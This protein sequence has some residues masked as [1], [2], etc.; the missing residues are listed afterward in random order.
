MC[1][2]ITWGRCL[3]VTCVMCGFHCWGLTLSL[4]VIFSGQCLPCK[5]STRYV[6][7][8]RCLRKPARKQDIELMLQLDQFAKYKHGK[9]WPSNTTIWHAQMHA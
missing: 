7:V 4:D 3:M 2:R 5:I 8:H 9:F 6:G 1:L